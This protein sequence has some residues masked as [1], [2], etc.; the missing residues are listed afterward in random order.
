[1]VEIDLA[2]GARELLAQFPYGSLDNLAFDSQDRLFVSRGGDGT[3]TEI[4]D[5]GDLRDVS[6]AGMVIPMG[7]ALS[8][9]DVF[10]GGA[11]NIRGYDIHSGM[12]TSVTRSVL[13][14][15]PADGTTGVAAVDDHLALPSWTNNRLLLWDPVNKSVVQEATIFAPIDVVKMGDYL[16]ISQYFGGT[17]TRAKLPDLVQRESIASGVGFAV[18]LAVAYSD[19]GVRDETRGDVMHSV[20]HPT[21]PDPGNVWDGVVE[22][23]GEWWGELVEAV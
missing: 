15:G 10:V 16:L 21:M 4:L 9:S 3:I 13:G 11:S 7:I 6:P 17:V 2:T 19:M 5:N 23:S 18:G 14:F 1:V 12:Q 20:C 8:G 22:E